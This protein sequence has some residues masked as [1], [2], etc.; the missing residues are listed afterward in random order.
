MIN[1]KSESEINKMRDAAKI[2]ADVMYAMKENIKPG[3]STYELDQIGYN[4]IKKAGAV[5]PTLG[6]AMPPYPAATCISIDEQVVHGIPRKEKFLEEGQ[7]ISL[8]LVVGYKGWMADAAR[9]FPVGNISEEKQILIAAAKD[10]FY[11]GYEQAII[12]NRIGDISAAVQSVADSR[13]FAVIEE[14]VG[15][16]IGREMHE[17]PS[18]PNY[19]TL[20]KGPRIQEGMVI[21]IEPMIALGSKEVYLEDDGW[22]AVMADGKAAA[23]YENT[24]AITSAGPEILTKMDF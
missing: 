20:R 8:D 14:F 23:H 11:A 4:V 18:V 24:I 19:K 2:L 10:C 22:T 1:I 17:D 9:T 6:Y 5:A 7:I 16:G 15:H 13:N 21:C 12:G 3:I